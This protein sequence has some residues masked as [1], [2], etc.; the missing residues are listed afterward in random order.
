MSELTSRLLC[1][2]YGL[3]IVSVT[4]I[5]KYFAKSYIFK[6]KVKLEDGR[7]S[8]DEMSMNEEL[9]YYQKKQQLKDLAKSSIAIAI[10]FLLT[11]ITFVFYCNNSILDCLRKNG[12]SNVLIDEICNLLLTLLLNSVLFAVVIYKNYRKGEFSMLVNVFKN[13]SQLKKDI[14]APFVEEWVFK[15]LFSII[16]GKQNSFNIQWFSPLVFSLCHFQLIFFFK[17]KY[18]W[19]GALIRARK[20]IFIYSTC[21][22]KYLNQKLPQAL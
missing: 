18:G 4:Y 3:S 22:Q 16:L 15:V 5:Y 10:T 20:F 2:A 14:I 9:I 17:N 21:N 19:L 12:F 8:V 7:T 13:M 6:Q 1:I 11:I